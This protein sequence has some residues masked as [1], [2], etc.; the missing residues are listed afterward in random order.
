MTTVSATRTQATSLSATSS[1]PTLRNGS[2]GA[3]VTQLQNLLRNKGYNISA[4]GDFGPKTEAAVKKFQSSKGL[5]ADGVVGPKTWAALKGGAVS[6]PGTPAGSKQVT[7]YVQGKPSTITVVP[8]GNG[9]YMRA[10]A[11]KNFMAM[12]KAAKAAGI[13]L[14]ATSGFRSMEEQKVLYQKYLNGTGNLAAKPGY[15]NHQNGI[16]MDIGG[17]GGYNTKAYNWL[18]NNAAKYGFKNDVAGEHW[19]WTYKGGGVA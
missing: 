10:D 17:I 9:K 7:A 12:Q 2:K 19:H 16:S 4:D 11:A 1:Q 14:T 6:N 13:N 15:S 8:V 18:K 5:V 3:A